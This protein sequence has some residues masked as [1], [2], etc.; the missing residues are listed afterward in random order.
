METV[1]EGIIYHLA[2]SAKLL[3]HTFKVQLMYLFNMADEKIN[4]FYAATL[5]RCIESVHPLNSYLFM[6]ALNRERK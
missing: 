3:A 2:T 5:F 4:N 1:Q 6:T